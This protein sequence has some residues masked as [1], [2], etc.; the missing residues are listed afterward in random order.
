MLAGRVALVAAAAPPAGSDRAPAEIALLGVGGAVLIAVVA[1]GIRRVRVRGWRP[2]GGLVDDSR[3]R[4]RLHRR[5]GLLVPAVAV[6]V[7]AATLGAA[8]VLG[9]WWR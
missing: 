7:L 1:V 5:A 8:V 3:V 2:G 6:V 4:P 9:G